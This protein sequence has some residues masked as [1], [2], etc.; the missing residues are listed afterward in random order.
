MPDTNP[1]KPATPHSDA[2]FATTHWTVV[3]AA[4]SPDSSRYREALETLCQTYWFPLYAYL[5][6]TGFG[7]HEA[8]DYTQEFFGKLLDRHSLSRVTPGPGKFRSFLITAL[9]N[10]IADQREKDNALK[11]QGSRRMLSL[12]FH[13]A[14]S[15]Y[16]LQT[17]SSLTPE[18]LF[19]KSW[20]LEILDRAMN[21]LEIDMARMNKTHLLDLARGH[22]GG[23][24]SST[25]HRKLAEQLGVT[26]GAAK[27]AVHRM[28]KRYREILRQE[29]AQTVSM[30][31]QIDE[32]IHD[33]FAA[34]AS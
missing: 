1:S 6:R 21:R 27:V 22:L 34:L 14:E 13:N 20:A 29:I 15:R 18:A 12:D 3:L 5:R 8:E 4:G 16:A 11:R 31:E 10:H 19:R 7:I 30:P 17:A 2:R 23:K 33:L 25:P 32:E 9:K 24:D 26:E 28:R